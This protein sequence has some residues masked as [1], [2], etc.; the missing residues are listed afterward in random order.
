[1]I[2]TVSEGRMAIR[3]PEPN[4]AAALTAML[5]QLDR[6]TAFMM[7][8]PDERDPDPARLAEWITALD[9]ATD[10]YLALFDG[11][12][13]Q[14][15]VHAERGRFRRNRHS[16]AVVIG[17]LEAARGGGWGKRLLA[18]VDD[19]AAGVGVARLELTVMVHNPAAIR[20]YE[21][22][23][24]RLEGRR[25]ASLRVDGGFVDEFAMSKILRGVEPA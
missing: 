9:P 8:E 17:L 10:C 6:Q 18:A 1:M 21:K 5:V 25:V 24:Y 11:A 23:G 19:W 12:R 13:P 15:F 20:L 4:E 3:R 22:C 14:G 16:A 2:W 7:L